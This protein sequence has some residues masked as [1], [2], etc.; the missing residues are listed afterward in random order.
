MFSKT[1]RINK[2]DVEKVMKKGVYYHSSFFSLKVLPNNLEKS[3]FAVIISKKVA[4]SAVLRNRNKRRVREVI[5]KIFDKLNFSSS[6]F[7][8]IIKKDLSTLPYSD[9]L[10]E[11]AE[12]FETAQKSQKHFSA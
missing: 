7:I 2:H 1:Y 3:L 10:K 9:L 6:Y 12:I 8:F 11:V 5:K 4:K